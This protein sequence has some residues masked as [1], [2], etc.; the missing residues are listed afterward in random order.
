MKKRDEKQMKENIYK[1]SSLSTTIDKIRGI[2]SENEINVTEKPCEGFDGLYSVRLIIDGIGLGTN[3]KG[4]SKEIALASAYGELMERI[5]NYALYKF[6][7][8]TIFDTANTKFYY[9]P[10]ETSVAFI[11]YPNYVK[12]FE[13]AINLTNIFDMKKINNS[14]ECNQD[15]FLCIP[16]VDYV[17]GA[18]VYL[19]AKLIEHIYASN[20]MAAGNTYSEALVQ[21]ISEIF[22]RY[23]NK[24]IGEGKHV[25][26]DLPVEKINFSQDMLNVLDLI[27]RKG[28]YEITFKDCSLGMGLPVVGMYFVDKETGKYFFKFGAHPILSIAAER[29]ITELFQGRKFINSNLWLKSFSFIES[30]DTGRNFEKIF[31]D[32][33]G[34]YPYTIFGD[35][36]SYDLSE[37]WFNDDSGV[38]DNNVL[39]KFMLEIITRN[40]WSFFHRNVSFLGFPAVHGIIPEISYV[41]IIDENY[42]RKRHEFLNIKKSISTINSCD[43][44][45]LLSI[46]DFIDNNYYAS[47]DTILPLVGLPLNEANIFSKTN[48]LYLKFLLYSKI[49]RFNEALECLD[50]FITFSN[51]SNSRNGTIYRCL[52]ETIYALKIKNIPIKEVKK[53][54][55]KIFDN[56]I[57]D[58][59]IE[60]VCFEKYLEDFHQLK[61]F[62][63][64]SC[65][66][67]DECRHHLIVKFHEKISA[68]YQ[69]WMESSYD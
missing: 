44:N 62:D 48:N 41:N 22:E 67:V 61:C 17:S 60:I 38:A 7:Y 68:K 5:Q 26:P 1:D 59:S 47:H 11:Q 33:N 35:E 10:D 43:N 50:S 69:E 8:P 37:S 53:V 58:S 64:D 2:L 40:N 6:T 54:L 25:P 45:D 29:T 57:V 49:K 66:Y 36:S 4:M 24:I 13:N 23:S 14:Y 31:R 52:R 55:L 39:L 34:T 46:I 56:E 21:S 42:I 9:A 12:G 27:K 30:K 51:L 63:C 28:K 16:Y 19:P 3:G 20:G 15:M 65:N 32:G 18:T